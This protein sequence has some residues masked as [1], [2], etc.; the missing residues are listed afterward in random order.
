MVKKILCLVVCAVI[1]SSVLYGCGGSAS[2]SDSDGASG[3]TASTATQEAK[4]VNIKIFQNQP[5]II[6]AYHA[7]ID[8]YEK[9]NPN[10]KIDIEIMQADYPTILKSKIA[11]GDIPDVFC[12]TVGGELK[13]YEEYTADLTN[14]PLAA[15]MTD[16]VRK[17]VTYNGKVLG[18]PYKIDYNGIVYN[19]K[20][21]ADA[22]I[23]ELPMT[24]AQLEEACKKLQAKGITPFGNAYKEWWVEKHIFEHFLGAEGKGD[25]AKLVGD[26]IAGTTTFKDHPLL[27][28]Y[29]D[30]IDLTVKYGL[31]KPLEIDFNGM[32]SAIGTGK[33]AMITGTSTA[34]EAG[35]IKLNPDIQLGFLGYPISDDEKDTNL[36]AG[37][38]Q[39]VRLYKDSPVL[40][41]TKKL[42]NWLYTSDYGKAWFGK[43]AKVNPPIKDAPIPDMQLPKS[44]QELS[45]TLPVVGNPEDFSLDAFHQKFGETTQA[46]IAK[47]KTKDQAIDEIQKAWI[48]FG[49]AK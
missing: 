1:M 49:A 14:E 27:E 25:P 8:E 28:K 23:T 40:A 12:T 2:K 45:K 11:S 43:V 34:S 42:Y 15:A 33:V 13:A 32:V 22:G 30:F 10:V 44:F 37:G 36:C 48:K 29:F 35:I 21:F 46:Y 20:L 19:K 5:E 17:S 4:P 24:V 18:F 39:C 6:D 9:E 47:S 31:P 26:F 41:E 16:D 38:A 3:S 7:Y